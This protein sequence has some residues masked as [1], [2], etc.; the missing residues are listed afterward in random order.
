MC[1]TVVER[2]CLDNTDPIFY[3]P[4]INILNRIN[5]HHVS[6]RGKIEISRDFTPATGLDASPRFET[7]WVSCSFFLLSV[8][9]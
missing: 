7:R 9:F 2:I 3:Y 6:V 4:R 1:F 5:L 8:V